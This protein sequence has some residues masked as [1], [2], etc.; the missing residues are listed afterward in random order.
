MELVVHADQVTL[1]SGVH[2]HCERRL[3]FA[4]YRFR[5]EVSRV[6]V[7][8]ER[9]GAQ[10]GSELV[11]RVTADLDLFRTRQVATEHRGGADA[12][13]CIDA[14]VRALARKLDRELRPPTGPG[15]RGPSPVSA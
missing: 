12:Y 13:A 4:L 14:A 8:V 10:H 5:S 7:V 3:R 11:C 2:V 15:G 1:G 6:T 9:D